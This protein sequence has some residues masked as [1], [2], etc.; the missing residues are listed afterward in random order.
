MFILKQGSGTLYGDINVV[1]QDGNVEFFA[2]PEPIRYVSE[3]SSLGP[4]PSGGR[5]NALLVRVTNV[6]LSSLKSNFFVPAQA[7]SNAR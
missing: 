5:I 7:T 4:Y 6:P 1:G 3:P 2:G